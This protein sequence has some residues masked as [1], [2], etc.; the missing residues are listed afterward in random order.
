M[1]DYH[2]HHLVPQGGYYNAVTRA[3]WDVI[4]AAPT[5]MLPCF[6]VHPWHAEGVDAGALAFELDE[7]LSRYPLAGVG[8]CGLDFSDKGL[9]AASREA[10]ELLLH[11]QLGAAFRHER[12]AHLHGTKAWAVLLEILRARKVAGTLPRVHLHAW[13]GSLEMAREFLALGATFSVGLRDLSHPKAQQR[14]GR[15]SEKE[16]FAESD[17]CPADFPRTLALLSLLRN[18]L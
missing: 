3:D 9:A 16:L 18:P 14:Y 13:N 7:Y 5:P 10:Q 4:A 11:V 15:L 12:L 17:D 8:E 1:I 6:G 2:T